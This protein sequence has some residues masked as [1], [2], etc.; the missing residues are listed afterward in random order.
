M[1]RRDVRDQE[2]EVFL[3]QNPELITYETR[4]EV[5][6]VEREEEP[7][8][9]KKGGHE[10]PTR[11]E[12][13]VTRDGEELEFFAPGIKGDRDL[14]QVRFVDSE[15]GG[16]YPGS[17][18]GEEGP[19]DVEFEGRKEL[20]VLTLSE[21]GF[22]ISQAAGKGGPQ[23][24][25]GGGKDNEPPTTQDYA[26]DGDEVLI[27]E[28]GFFGIPMV[29]QPF[30]IE[31]PKEEEDLGNT[32]FGID[33]TV[34]AGR[35]TI[36]LVLVDYNNEEQTVEATSDFLRNGDSGSLSAAM[37]EGTYEEAYIRVT[38]NL[39]IGVVGVDVTSNTDSFFPT[40][41]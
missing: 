30:G 36:E 32:E 6:E 19:I 2:L 24:K 15:A 41:S 20:D 13:E 21:N 5:V 26:I 4:F 14:S 31:D 9:F 8:N 40:S 10:R 17:D 1:S 27:F 39:E 7:E 33:F 34:L 22:G 37:E 35:G 12:V 29:P 18:L 11:Y 23:N 28:A 16:L 38:G 3:G 25:K